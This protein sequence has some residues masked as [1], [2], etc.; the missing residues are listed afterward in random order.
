MM[1]GDYTLLSVLFFDHVYTDREIDILYPE[2][3]VYSVFS[4]LKALRVDILHIKSECDIYFKTRVL[5]YITF[6]LMK[7]ITWR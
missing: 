2:V 3:R 6:T 7:Y 4:L 5:K 1:R